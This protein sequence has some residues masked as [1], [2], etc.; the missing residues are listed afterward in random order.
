MWQCIPSNNITITNGA[1][2]CIEFWTNEGYF[3]TLK[4]SLETRSKVTSVGLKLNRPQ[5]Q[6]WLLFLEHDR[7]RSEDLNVTDGL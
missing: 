4:K 5:V 1:A 3:D 6:H 7:L 2:W